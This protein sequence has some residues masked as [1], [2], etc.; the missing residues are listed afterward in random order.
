MTTPNE[1]MTEAFKQAVDSFTKTME[2]GVK[3]QEDAAR[4]WN[5]TVARNMDDFRGQWEKLA[6]ENAPFSKRNVERFRRF[7]DEQSARRL[8]VIRQTMD[9]GKAKDSRDAYDRLL[10]LW[11]TSLDS[12]RK[13]TD[14][15]A[16]ANAELLESWA[17]IV[18]AMPQA[19]ERG[20][21]AGKKG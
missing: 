11:K 18:R 4:F 8:E 21:P 14:V 3:F 13:S 5:D 12:L 15:V 10:E 2:A 20:A 1:F 6:A 16:Q 9:V 19:G 7:L 17:E